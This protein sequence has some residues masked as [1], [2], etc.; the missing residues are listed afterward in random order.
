M[1]MVLLVDNGVIRDDS[2]EQGD[3]MVYVAPD[4]HEKRYLTEKLR[5]DSYDIESALD[6]DEVSRIELAQERVS[7]IWKQPKSATIDEQFQLEVSSMGLFLQDEHLIIVMSEGSVPFSAK[8]FQRV[9]SLTDFLLRYLLHTVRHYV[10][11]LKVIKQL[12]GTLE[13]K[14]TS[15]MENQYLLQMFALSESLVYYL[16][17]IEANGAVLAKLRNMADRLALRREQV[18]FLDDVLLENQQCARQAN[19][20]S[21][22]LSGLMDARGTIVNNNMNVLLK[23]LT[24]INIVFLPLNLV[25]SILGMSEF[26][27]MTGNMDWRVSYSLFTLGM[28]LFGWL[29]WLLVVR[30]IERYP[31]GQT[32]KSI[33]KA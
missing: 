17:A 15:S 6:P 12:S 28:V 21:T 22:I 24:L 27:V 9:S 26:T 18:D 16:D 29:T 5:L 33:H 30:I 10:G 20:Y 19:I 3:I 7:I 25:A 14:I 1:R 31:D 11:H 32:R 23:N 4:N 8:E 2:Q 13:S